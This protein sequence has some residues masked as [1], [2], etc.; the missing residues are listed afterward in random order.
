MCRSIQMLRGADPPATDTEVREAAL[1]YVR[2]ISGYRSP[3]TANSAAF[4]AAV[5]EIAAATHRL[6][7]NLVVGPG[8]RPAVP[9]QRRLSA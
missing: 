4:D 8:S 3:S 2:K 5:D 9:I 6:L 1:Q 7:D